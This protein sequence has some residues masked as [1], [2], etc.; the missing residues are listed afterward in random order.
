MSGGGGDENRSSYTARCVVMTEVDKMD[1]AGLTSREAP[2]VQQIEN[3]SA[4]YPEYWR[5]CH[6]E[7]TVLIPE[8]RVWTEYC[9]GTQSKIACPCPHCRD[10][11]T[12]EGEHLTGWEEADCEMAG[13]QAAYFACPSCG[14]KLAEAERATMNRA[15]RVLH[16]GQ[17]IDRAG[18]HFRG[19]TPDQYLR[20]PL[21][22]LQ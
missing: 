13:R 21:E 1:T 5:C 22:R 15:G 10:F 4:S 7:C 8:G 12:P 14:H 20:A 9:R 11:V 19:N 3:R 2:P 6:L 18:D 16:R 17:S